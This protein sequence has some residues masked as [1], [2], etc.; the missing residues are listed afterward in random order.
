MK[1][2]LLNCVEI[3]FSFDPEDMH[4]CAVMNH[5]RVLFRKDVEKYE[6]KITQLEILSR[7]A[8]SNK[9]NKTNDIKISY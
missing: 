4:M 2:L 3:T 7:S 8:C 5:L 9:P 1:R 6:K